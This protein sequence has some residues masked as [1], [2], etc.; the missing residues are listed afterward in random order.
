MR[1]LEIQ[2]SGEFSLIPVDDHKTHPYAMLSYALKDAQEVT[3]QELARALGKTRV[4]MKRSGFV[5]NKRLEM[6]HNTSGWIYVV[7]TSQILTSL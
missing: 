2:S 3:Y 6:A 5:E 4:A 1:L 7:L